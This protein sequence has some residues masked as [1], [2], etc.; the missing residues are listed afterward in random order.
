MSS[1]GEISVIGRPRSVRPSTSI[2]T[3]FCIHVV[4]HL[5]GVAMTMSSSRNTKPS[6]RALSAMNPL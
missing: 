6:Q 2:P 1:H 5:A 4:P 3:M